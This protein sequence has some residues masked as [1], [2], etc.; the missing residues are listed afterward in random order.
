MYILKLV[1]SSTIQTPRIP[2]MWVKVRA[3]ALGLPALK[4][5]HP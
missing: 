3:E 2:D 5:K 4:G 1:L